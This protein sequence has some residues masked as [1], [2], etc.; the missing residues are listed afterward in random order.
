MRTRRG[1]LVVKR[2]YLEKVIAD[3]VV[4]EE[5]EDDEGESRE[6]SLGG[7]NFPEFW[8]VAQCQGG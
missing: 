4:E 5:L 3:G 2:L 6:C 7:G 8:S 1:I